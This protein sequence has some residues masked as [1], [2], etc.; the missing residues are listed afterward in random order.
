MNE[1]NFNHLQKEFP[2]LFNIGTAAEYNLYEDSVTSFF[3]LR[4]FVER[5]TEMAKVDKIESRYQALKAKI[6][7]LPQA[8]LAKAFRGELVE[9]LDTD[10]NAKE[11]LEE[12]VALRVEMSIKKKK[13]EK[14]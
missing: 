1:S 12:I 14:R 7:V 10:G 13:R 2:I 8:I 4:Q 11:L 9:Q 5:L 6:D 3:K